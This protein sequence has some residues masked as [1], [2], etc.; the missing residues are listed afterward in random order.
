[1]KKNNMLTVGMDIGDR[2]SKVCV[3]DE[4]NGEAVVVEETRIRTIQ[5]DVVR[6][7]GSR[8]PM[9]V[10]MEVGTHS[11]WMSR[12]IREYGHEVIVA[13][14]RKLRFIF[15]NDKKND[16]IDAEMIA[17][18]ARMDRK[19]LHPLEHRSEVDAEAMALIRSRDTLVR[20]RTALVNHVR[21]TVKSNGERMRGSSASRF[22][23]LID[24]VPSVL[25][26]ALAPVMESIESINERIKGL[27][28]EIERVSK[29]S[30]PETEVLR[31][32]PGVG[33]I[34]ALMFVLAIADPE[35]FKR[36]RSVGAYVG[37]VPKQDQSGESDPQLRIAKTGNP[38]LRRLLVSAA[39]YILG[40]FGPDTDLRRCG[41][42]IAERGGK[43]AKKRAAVA[44]AR[45]LS[46]L[47]LTL[48]K[49]GEEYEPL[50][51]GNR[52]SGA[53]A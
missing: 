16:D 7:F 23:K 43:R 21:G 17:R 27:D 5:A 36:N 48:L 11:P 4:E 15:G 53:A 3:V 50:R 20:T 1:M 13:N 47:L 32:V 31:Q 14:A 10:A 24:E 46:V 26:P 8:E 9:V 41:L 6:Y 52:E 45:K 22:H 42:R 38:Y 44:V 28:R 49:T 2:Y 51:Q 19:L 35:R 39:H 40:P 18:V 30:Y 25:A 12:M 34:T 29:E 33:P 37:L